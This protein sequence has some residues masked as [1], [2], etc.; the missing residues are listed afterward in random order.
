[1]RHR[2]MVL[3]GAL[4]GGARGCGE[5]VDTCDASARD[6]SVG[7]ASVRDASVSGD[8]QQTIADDSPLAFCPGRSSVPD[9]PQVGLCEAGFF[10]D[11]D[12][13]CG[14][15]AGDF[16]G[17]WRCGCRKIGD[18]TCLRRC[19]GDGGCG[20]GEVCIKS[21]LFWGSDISTYIVGLCRSR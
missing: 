1:M 3:L 13:A 12:Y 14:P 15:P 16:D 2:G 21:G 5:G 18:R 7:D 11:L 8:S 20:A 9:R 4:L 19:T 6:A 10:P 17:G